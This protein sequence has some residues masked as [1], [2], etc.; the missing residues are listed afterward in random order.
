MEDRLLGL[1]RFGQWGGRAHIGRFLAL[2]HVLPELLFDHSIPVIR[3]FLRSRRKDDLL[4]DLNL[5]HDRSSPVER[6]TGNAKG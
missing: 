4:D 2:G 1:L 6:S 3:P 5:G